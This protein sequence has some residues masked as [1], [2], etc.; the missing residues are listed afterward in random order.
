[1]RFSK[2]KLSPYV[3]SLAACAGLMGWSASS[4]YAG[5]FR[6]SGHQFSMTFQTG[7]TG[8]QGQRVRAGPRVAEPEVREPAAQLAGPQAAQEHPSPPGVQLG[9]P[10]EQRVRRVQL[11]RL[12]RQVALDR[13]AHQAR[14]A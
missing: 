14:P 10:L 2:G 7:G 11:D 12:A 13:P 9:H 5:Q 4:L 1:M 6:G 8:G 3:T